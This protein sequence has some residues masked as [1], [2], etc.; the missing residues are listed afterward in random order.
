MSHTNPRARFDYQ[1]WFDRHV[2]E[3]TVAALEARDAAFAAQYAEAPLSELAGYLL[4]QA[5]ALRH[6]PAPTEIDG[7]EFIAQRFG[8]WERAVMAAG[9]PAP[10]AMPKLKNT[11]RYRR[12]KA[13][14]EPLFYA[15]SEAKKKAKRERAA[16][17]HAAEQARLKEKK[18]LEREKKEARDAIARQRE[19]QRRAEQAAERETGNG[20]SP[21]GG[22]AGERIV[23]HEE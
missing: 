1:S 13:V 3:R 8:S 16:Q 21:S 22:T 18:R 9:L 12:E 5:Q 15:E 2:A 17:R 10:K 4:R 23:P 14:Q 11:A 20:S 6:T 7:G 19:A